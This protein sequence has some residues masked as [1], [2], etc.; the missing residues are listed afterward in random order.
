MDIFASIGLIK[1]VLCNQSQDQVGADIAGEVTDYDLR[2][3][4]DRKPKGGQHPEFIGAQ[5]PKESLD[6]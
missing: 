5:G 3:P 4:F 2:L 1:K 6:K